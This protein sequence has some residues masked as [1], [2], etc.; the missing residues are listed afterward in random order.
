M[1]RTSRTAPLALCAPLLALA[2]C[3]STSQSADDALPFHVALIPVVTS[4]H[5]PV[6][7]APESDDESVK[8]SLERDVLSQDLRASLDGPCFARASL[9]ALPANV[10]PA[11]FDAWSAAERDDHW[12]AE[13]ERVGADLVLECEVASSER[14]VGASNDKFWLNLPLFLLG[15]PSCYFVGDRTY[16]GDARLHAALYEL[17]ALRSGRATLAD[18]RSRVVQAE[19]R[20]HSEALTFLERADGGFG[21]YLLSFVVPAGLLAQDGSGVEESLSASLTEQLST[22]LTEELARQREEIADA[23]RVAPFR[24]APDV[25]VVAADGWLDVAGEVLLRLGDVERMEE[26]VVRHGGAQSR[27]ELGAGV[28]D[29]ALSSRREELRRIP[30]EAR[31]PYAEHERFVRIALVAGG[32][33]P[34]VRSFTLPIRGAHD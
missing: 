3:A 19:A 33:T 4:P 21:Q 18:G 28:R 23:D 20:F 25:R 6:A 27:V 34:I 22:G 16:T 9:L 7:K 26:C 32:R 14:A 1:K 24:L 30:F 15:G 13:A 8:L 12:L 5:V 10:S 11:E 29:E 17:H 2:S 31:L